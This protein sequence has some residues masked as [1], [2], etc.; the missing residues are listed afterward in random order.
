M[1]ESQSQG[2]DQAQ[3]LN[4]EL[5]ARREKLVTLREN[6]IAFP[7]D[8]RRDSISDHLHAEFDAKEN[9]ELEEL[10]IEVTVAGRMM[11]RRI[12]GKASFVTLQDVGGRIQL[13]VSRDD[14]AEGIYN[15]QFKKWDLGDIL[16]ARGKLFKT[17]TGEL[18][19][20]CTELRLLT[21]ALRPLPDKFHGLA[22]QE[23]RYRQR[24]LD[25]IAND[26]S[27]NTFRIRSNVMAA[28]RRFMV[29]NGFMEVET[30][31][32]QVI[33]G[34]ASARP[35]ITHHNALDIDMYLRIAPELY[36]KRLVVGGFERVFE[37]NRN[38][39]NEGVSPRHNPEFTM[40]ELYMA[41]ADYKDLIVLT[42]NL[43]RTLT[44][45]VLGSTTVV[46]GDQ[47][48]DFG[49]PFDKLTM[50]E[51][52]CKYRPETNVADL[53][54]LEK[55]TAIALSLGIKIE[56]SWGLGRIVTEIFEETAESSLI[57]PTFITEY[58]AEV[59]PLARRNDQNS[60][61]TDRFEFFIGGREIGNGFSE[62]NDAE[63]QAERFA[64]QVNAKDAG[65]D[66]AMF[67][68]EDYVTALEH[69]LPPTAGL[70]IGIDRM[71]MLFT[72]SHTI[73]DVILFPAMR[74]QK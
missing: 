67:Y 32:M 57:Q 11:T 27:R 36:L 47:T 5:K 58:P 64:Q 43:F 54:D 33:P 22:D 60:E 38:F 71:V 2:A 15:E 44:Q 24:Y 12:M 72:N 13:Y 62:L 49:K 61:I 42:E 17:K 55:A 70:G 10:G 31:M 30:P 37:I 1:A 52:I 16:G 51:A 8:F 34:G 23:T 74:P 50:R 29:D 4:N 73:R 59:S 48:F 3:D 46:Y 7:N 40:M 39:R 20:H 28:I 14:L 65:D 18:S 41:Y 63:D 21:K 9:E 66:E 45:D 6:G 26:D 56:K 69:G 53:D 35:F 19:I 25:L 68:D